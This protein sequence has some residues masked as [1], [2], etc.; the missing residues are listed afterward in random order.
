MLFLEIINIKFDEVSSMKN[1]W[2]ERFGQSTYVYGKAPNEF[3][4]E[5]LN[6]LPKGKL[7]LPA[8]GEG[9]NAVYAAVK[10]WNV[11]AFDYSVEGQKKALS[12]A[13][14]YEVKIDYQL[15]N[16]NKFNASEN[17][18]VI[19]LIFAHFTGEERKTLF[20]KLDSCLIPGG[21]LIMEVF[22]KNQIG[23][24]SGGPKNLDLLYSKDEIKASFP[25]IDFVILEETKI[26]LNEGPSHQG[27]AVVIRAV[28]KKRD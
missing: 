6:Q 24:E 9:R 1:F 28:G 4:V 10:G 14:E 15:Q 5:Q 19:A 25:N 18:D 7:L 26:S 11:T 16:T 13:K 17:Y 8:E 20:N 27:D 3:F 22:S 23:R 21:H 12:L 2:N